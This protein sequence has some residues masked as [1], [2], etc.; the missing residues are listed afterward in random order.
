MNSDAGKF[1]DYRVTNNPVTGQGS[2]GG[3]GESF[4][5]TSESRESTYFSGGEG[6]GVAGA[7]PLRFSLHFALFCRF[8]MS[9]CL[10]CH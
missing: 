10:S 9:I 5:V 1:H 6:L 4:W 8:S 2:E 3:A 7:T